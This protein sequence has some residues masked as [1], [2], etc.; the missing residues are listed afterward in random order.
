MNH[1]GGGRPTALGDAITQRLKG[2]LL[3][4]KGLK[5]ASWSVEVAPHQVMSLV[6]RQHL[7]NASREQLLQLK[8]IDAQK[9]LG[10]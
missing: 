6:V 5:A 1:L 3:R 10:S 8:L 9:K 2:C 7:T 4:A